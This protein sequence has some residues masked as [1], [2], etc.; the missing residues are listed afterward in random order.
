MLKALGRPEEAA[1]D[2][3]ESVDLYYEFSAG[4]DG[5]RRRPD[6]LTDADFERNIA[7]WSS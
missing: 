6:E 4:R 3:N 1:S 5:V 2:R 7:F